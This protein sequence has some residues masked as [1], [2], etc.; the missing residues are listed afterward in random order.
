[1]KGLSIGI[2]KKPQNIS[3]TSVT[4]LEST[5]FADKVA[6][7]HIFKG[8][9]SAITISSE[10]DRV[11]SPIK[12]DQPIIIAESHKPRFEITRDM[13]GDVVV[14][15]PWEEKAKLMADFRPADGYKKMICVE[16]GSVS[17]WNTL[18]ASDTWEGGQTIKAL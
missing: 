2:D 14:W 18:E 16:T 4:G 17:S 15:N 10:V 8:D 5:P 13:L 3:H 9:L 1:M 11:Y 6:K 7:D 12:L